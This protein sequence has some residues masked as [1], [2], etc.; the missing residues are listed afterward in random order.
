MTSSQI[1]SVAWRASLRDN[2]FQSL[3]GKRRDPEIPPHQHSG[4]GAKR[5]DQVSRCAPSASHKASSLAFALPFTALVALTAL[6]ALIAA[7][8]NVAAIAANAVS[9]SFAG[10]SHALLVPGI[11]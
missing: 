5:E 8:S 3:G 1:Q 9:V 7:G 10:I 2:I 11:A 6:I 4:L